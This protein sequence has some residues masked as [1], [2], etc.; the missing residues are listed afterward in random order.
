M[1]EVSC[2][3]KKYGDRTAVSQ[4][5]FSVKEGEIVGFLG[6]N[7]AGKSTTMN[8]LTGYLRPTEGS[9]TID[10]IDVV[11]EPEKAKR[12][13]GYLPEHPPLYLDMTVEEQLAFTCDLRDIKGEEKKKN[14]DEVCRMV[15]IED[16]RGRMIK[17]LSKGY[18]QRVGLA[19]AML[20]DPKIL[21]LDEP[22]V[23]LDPKQIIDI[24]NVIAEL[25]K[26]RTVIL[27]SHILPEI[28]AVCERVL[29]INRG[30]IVADGALDTL[31]DTLMKEKSLTVRVVGAGDEVQPILSGIEGVVACEE[32]GEIEKGSQD[33]KLETA[34]GTDV[35][36]EVVRRLTAASLP[37]LM[38]KT[39]DLSLEEI[40][41][42]LTAEQAAALPEEGGD[43]DHGS[44]L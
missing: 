5:S 41:L 8:M 13:I 27:S 32:L 24:R 22:T 11:K 42:K 29:I 14:I 9:I 40:F 44:D 19:Q 37:V 25:G 10:G 2:I 33:Y 20:G 17:N 30:V 4:V 39:N 38:L 12:Q 36:A 21:I 3:T 26:T 15:K 34:E 43:G 7:G 31:S 6:P 28:S 18:R 16:V 1:I 35:R 23:G